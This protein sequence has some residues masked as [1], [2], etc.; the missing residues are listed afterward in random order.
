MS[1]GIVAGM[2]ALSFAAVPA[3]RAFCQQ[4]GFA[5]TPRIEVGAPSPLEIVDRE[6]TIRFNGD[7][8]QG[9]AWDF[10]PSQISMTLRPGETAL[11]FFEAVNL[12]AR[13]IT[14]T[15]TFNVTPL[16]AATPACLFPSLPS[17]PANPGVEEGLKDIH[18]EI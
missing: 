11:A 6:M 9:L 4:F 12:A 18:Q 17:C 1:I 8:A 15:A 14:G 16:Q 13:P 10:R 7:T 3:Y 2:T 5:G